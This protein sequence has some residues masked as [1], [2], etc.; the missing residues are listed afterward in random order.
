ML[1]L[2]PGILHAFLV[3]AVGILAFQL[4]FTSLGRHDLG[5]Q[6]KAPVAEAV[7]LDNI[8]DHKVDERDSKDG[9]TP[10]PAAGGD[11]FAFTKD[12]IHREE[13]GKDLSEENTDSKE[14]VRH[15]FPPKSRHTGRE[16]DKMRS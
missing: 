4:V 8:E 6:L 12:T 5:S 1:D 9:N 13:E 3:F 2:A 10:R 16:N 11:I 14:P 15:V 7:D